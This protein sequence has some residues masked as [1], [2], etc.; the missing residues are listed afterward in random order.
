MA[1]KGDDKIIWYQYFSNI[2][3]IYWI[4]KDIRNGEL[5]GLNSKKW[6]SH[7]PIVNIGKI[8]QANKAS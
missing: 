7:G 2:Y 8:N 6:R 4:N 1:T 5:I 3:N